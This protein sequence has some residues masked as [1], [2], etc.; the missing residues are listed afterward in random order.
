[1]KRQEMEPGRQLDAGVFGDG[2]PLEHGAHL[3]DADVE[4][5]DAVGGRR[6]AAGRALARRVVEDALVGQRRRRRRR[7]RRHQQKEPLHRSCTE[8]S[9][10]LLIVISWP[11]AVQWKVELF[12]FLDLE[13]N[14]QVLRADLLLG[15]SSEVLIG[16]LRFP[17]DPL[18]SLNGSDRQKQ[19][20]RADWKKIGRRII[21][22]STSKRRTEMRFAIVS[23]LLFLVCVFFLFGERK[24]NESSCNIFRAKLGYRE[25]KESVGHAA[26]SAHR[27]LLAGT[28]WKEKKRENHAEK[29]WITS[30][31]MRSIVSRFFV[32]LIRTVPAVINDCGTPTSISAESG[33][34]MNEFIKEPRSIG[35]TSTGST[36]AFNEKLGNNSLD[37]L[38]PMKNEV[39]L[40]APRM[41]RWKN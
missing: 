36:V 41:I 1:M 29:R 17:P 15:R 33:D 10:M 35:A 3:V 31:S 7:R 34:K 19:G 4:A 11:F 37:W 6:R 26:S 12:D 40:T 22:G 28:G 24:A 38:L 21:V 8:F 2:R 13:L 30:S 14:F 20:R 18:L 23:F 39:D 9:S 32:V 16:P 27:R 25:A 5:R